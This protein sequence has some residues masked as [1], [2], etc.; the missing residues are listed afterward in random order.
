M[1]SIR[2]VA[3][4]SALTL[5]TLV[6]SA[7]AAAAG[8]AG[9]TEPATSAD[10]LALAASGPT[11]VAE[12]RLLDD[13]R[14]PLEMGT[15]VAGG[16]FKTV[17]MEKELFQCRSATGGGQK[18]RDLETC[19]EIVQDRTGEL[20]SVS[21]ALH[22][23]DRSF[24]AGTVACAFHPLQLGSTSATPLDGC[25]I[26]TYNVPNDPVEMNVVAN[27]RTVKTIKVDKEWY[28]CGAVIRDV[29]Q[30]TEIMEAVAFDQGTAVGFRITLVRVLGVVCAKDVEK[31]A[32]T[33]CRRF[34]T[35]D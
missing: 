35:V 15:A 1:L 16:L 21:V 12:C 14:F 8:E 26:A 20:L 3:L 32:I 9:G 4:T 23:C 34:R 13:S 10:A 28:R 33:G 25:D 19:I 30:C 18:I 24:P 11:G 7:P 5:A 31:G 29:Y 27:G 2:R 6:A 17:A 22:I